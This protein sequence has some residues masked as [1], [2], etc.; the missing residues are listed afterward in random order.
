MT[1]MDRWINPDQWVVDLACKIF[2]GAVAREMDELAV[3]D[4]ILEACKARACNQIGD[5]SP[6]NGE[7]K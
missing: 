3:A 6:F 2:Y 7:S 4:L 1:D 5:R